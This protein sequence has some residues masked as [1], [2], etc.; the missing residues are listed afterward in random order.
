[1]GMA[2][3]GMITSKLLDRG[4]CGMSIDLNDRI[5]RL[6]ALKPPLITA[7]FPT[8][9]PHARSLSVYSLQC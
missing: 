3:H 2:L 8:F 6:A 5:V 9:P 4:S 1:M 7:P